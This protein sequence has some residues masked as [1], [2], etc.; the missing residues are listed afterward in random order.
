[1]HIAF[2]AGTGNLLFLDLVA[3]LIR[4]NLKK[5]NDYENSLIGDDDFKFVFFV[6]FP[7]QEDCIA[8]ELCTGLQKISERFGCDN[9]EFYPRFSND[10][11]NS[12]KWD[13][14]FIDETLARYS[15]GDSKVKKVWVCGPPIMNEMFDR[16]L[17]ELAPKYNINVHGIDVM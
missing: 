13:H 12:R 8:Y 3:H 11:K 16:S 15:K 6:S 5:L 10:P 9:F 17:E 14:E 4:K 1:V 2:T 7:K